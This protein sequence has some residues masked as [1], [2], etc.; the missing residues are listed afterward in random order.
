MKRVFFHELGHFVAHEL[1][2]RYYKGTGTKSIEIF[3]TEVD[4]NLFQGDAK[5]VCTADEKERDVPNI[6][7][8]PEVLAAAT[9]GC[10]FQAYYKKEDSFDDC[11]AKNGTEDT[12]LWKEAMRN[13]RIDDFRNEILADEREFYKSLWSKKEL[14][15]FI[16]L[17]QENY[18]TEHGTENYYVDIDKLR[19]DTEAFVTNHR[20][21]YDALIQKY[22]AYIDKHYKAQTPNIV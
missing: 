7:M 21:A 12:T 9:Y 6:E 5:V 3:P 14:E 2:K 22:Q 4:K 1:N 10:I 17:D 13:F 18:L 19:T 16:K 8:L 11:F 15:D 20:K